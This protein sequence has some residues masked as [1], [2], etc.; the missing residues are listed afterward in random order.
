MGAPKNCLDVVRTEQQSRKEQV[1]LRRG[2]VSL[3]RSPTSPHSPVCLEYHAGHISRVPRLDIFLEI[4]E[5]SNNG[6]FGL[7]LFK[8]L[9]SRLVIKLEGNGKT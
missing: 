7:I 8:F 3:R 4:G 2:A 1:S 6:H 9:K 5:S